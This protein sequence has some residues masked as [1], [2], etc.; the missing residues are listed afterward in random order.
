MGGWQTQTT[1]EH[2]KMTSKI[3][4]SGAT[5]SLLVISVEGNEISRQTYPVP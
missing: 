4:Y 1:C 2:D 3:S 5:S